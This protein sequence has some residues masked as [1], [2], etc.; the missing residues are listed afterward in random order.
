MSDDDGIDSSPDLIETLGRAFAFAQR[1]TRG[2]GMDVENIVMD[3]YVKILEGTRNSG[4]NLL[5]KLRRGVRSAIYHERK[6]ARRI[7]FVEFVE[8]PTSVSGT[9]APAQ[10][11]ESNARRLVDGVRGRFANDAEAIQYLDAMVDVIARGLK[12]KP[13]RISKELSIE[14]QSAYNIVRRIKAKAMPTFLSMQGLDPAALA[15]RGRL[16]GKKH[17]PRR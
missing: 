9:S 14:V 11:T 4:V 3:T 12:A 15:A 5:H 7:A 17:R 6:R 2:T 13:A 16:G 8:D 1:L 10:I